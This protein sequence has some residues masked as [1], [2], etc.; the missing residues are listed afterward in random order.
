MN[1]FEHGEVFVLE[2]GTETDLDLGTY[3]RF[4]D[5]D[6]TYENSITSGQVFLDIL[7]SERKGEYNGKLF[8]WF[9]ILLIK[10]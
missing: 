4:L 5:I 8:N 10:F 9:L 3:E 6:L 7:N 1:P 2:D